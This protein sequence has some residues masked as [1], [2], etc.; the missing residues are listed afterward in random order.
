MNGNLRAPWT[1]R[2][3]Q[4][5]LARQRENLKSI[6]AFIAFSG[7][8]GYNTI[9]LY[10][11]G[12]I[13]TPS[14]PYRSKEM[15]YSAEDVQAILRMAEKAG[16]EVIP[17]LATLG[18]AEHFVD[19]E[20]LQS[21]REAGSWYQ[22]MFC[23]SNPETYQFLDGY[24]RDIAEMFPSTNLHIGCDEAWALGS[25]PA[26]QKRL[27][28]GETRA[29]F[30]VQHIVRL[31]QL[32]NELGKRTWI[33]SD[34]FE[35]FPPGTLQRIPK[36][37][38]LCSWHYGAD[39]MSRE[40]IQGHFN[41]LRR[42]DVLTE[43][44]ALGFDTVVCPWGKDITSGL[45]LTQLAGARPLLGGLLT[46]WEMDKIF[47]P[48]I[49]APTALFGYL[50]SH[51]NESAEQALSVVFSSIFPHA[52][53]IEKYSLRHMLLGL[54][55]VPLFL[56]QVMTHGPLKLSEQRDFNSCECAEAILTLY[57]N[58]LPSGTERDIVQEYL[59][60]IRLL[61]VTGKL[62][63]GLVKM[64][65]SEEGGAD[66]PLAEIQALKDLATQR[67]AQWAS[68]R[69]GI[70][71][72]ISGKSILGLETEEFVSRWR[73]TPAQER[74]LLKAAL[75]LT[76][77]HSAPWLKIA[78]RGD[79]GWVTIFDET[80]KPLNLRESAYSL[81][82]PFFWSGCPPQALRIAVSGYG[83]QG[84]QY[85][86]FTINGET[87]IPQ[88]LT[89]TTGKVTDPDALLGDDAFVCFLGEKDTVKTL[90]QGSQN[91]ETIIE[92][93]MGTRFAGGI[94]RLRQKPLKKSE[95]CE[96]VN[97]SSG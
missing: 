89:R 17:G 54:P 47:L 87:L 49:L 56:R 4:L 96:S 27:Q 12:V 91:E 50:W 67:S 3:V 46:H 70:P 68:H 16:L 57:L 69:E 20:A 13:S 9:V 52:S 82:K 22:H 53:E 73:K 24:V 84:I 41:N 6:E 43:H 19:C 74:G 60:H 42:R 65:E 25:C 45:A 31:H 86:Q 2:A 88:S 79:E 94:N 61:I 76:E 38:V 37:I 44:S 33:W 78:L 15:S 72:E 55:H 23:P 14:F 85:L 40:G 10:L 5:D 58:R 29:D 93:E 59:T 51:P 39:Q 26:C 77:T 64:I 32:L 30:F 63:A 11:E 18:H 36:D 81:F 7:R 48:S 92:L 83:E 75:F 62:R 34:M 71:N 95:A 1:I 35:T 90:E 80:F 28:N 21:L 8:W 97:L 66:A